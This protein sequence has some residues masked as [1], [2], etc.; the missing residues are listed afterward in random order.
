LCTTGG[1]REG[2]VVG[3]ITTLYIKIHVEKLQFADDEE[4]QYATS[5]SMLLLN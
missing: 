2:G 3:N 1:P 5:E 4:Q